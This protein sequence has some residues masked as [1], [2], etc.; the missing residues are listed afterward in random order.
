MR[1]SALKVAMVGTIF[2]GV[3]VEIAPKR[4]ESRPLTFRA[5]GL[6]PLDHQKPQ[7]IT[8]RTCRYYR[9]YRYLVLASAWGMLGHAG[10][11]GRGGNTLKLHVFLRDLAASAR[12][13]QGSASGSMREEAKHEGKT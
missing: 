2:R 8:R 1:F 13:G 12:I 4:V 11:G 7:Y 9:Y 3:G 6:S 5:R 10:G